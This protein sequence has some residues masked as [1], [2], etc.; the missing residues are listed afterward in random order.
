MRAIR[1]FIVAPKSGLL[2]DTSN[3]ATAGAQLY[4]LVETAKLSTKSPMCSCA[5][6]LNGFRKPLQ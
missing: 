1:P 4:K 2:S 3:G 5:M 6:H